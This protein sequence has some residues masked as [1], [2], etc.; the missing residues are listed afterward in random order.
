MK[1]EKIYSN[2]NYLTL[3]I[4]YNNPYEADYK[5]K[6]IIQENSSQNI[7]FNI[8][9]DRYVDEKIDVKEYRIWDNAI[10]VLFNRDYRT[11]MINSPNHLTF[12]SSLLNLQK[13][14][15]VFMHDYLSLDYDKNGEE[16]IKVWPA[17]LDI[18]MPKMILKKE[19]LRHLMLI[20]SIQKI[21]NNR[22]RVYAD[23]MVGGIVT[24]SGEALIV[25]L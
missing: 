3:P 19:N 5:P 14:V 17:K 23:T 2:D 10:E 6:K 24:I 1:N 13:M 7:R 11:D 15:Y 20:K 18:K 8:M 16:L 22:Y 4:V 12:L 9:P 21:K 25:V